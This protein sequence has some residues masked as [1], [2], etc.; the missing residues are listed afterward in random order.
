[1]LFHDFYPICS[2]YTLF[3]SNH[4]CCT[5]YCLKKEI[6]D[7]KESWMQTLSSADELRTFSNS[8]KDILL[9][10]IPE[11]A[12]KI[13]VIPHSLDYLKNL[14]PITYPCI[15]PM[16][17]GIIGSIYSEIKGLEII[18]KLSNVMDLYIFGDISIKKSGIHNMGR[19]NINALKGLLEKNKI[20]VVLFSSVCA[21]TFSY[22]VSEVIALDLPLVGFPIGAQGEKIA[23]YK[24]GVLCQNYET[25]NIVSAIKQAYSLYSNLSNNIDHN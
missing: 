2:N 25:E 17:V 10:F 18:R 20:T 23:N 6:I 11:Y 22:V 9:K 3:Y 5:Q 15:Y 16:K 24:K 12:E 7:Y 1:M 21:E 14:T 19:Y 8:S 13:T 4:N